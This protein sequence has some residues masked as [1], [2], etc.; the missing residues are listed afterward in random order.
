MAIMTRTDADKMMRGLDN[1]ADVAAMFDIPAALIP[2]WLDARQAL[3]TARALARA[4]IARLTVELDK[5]TGNGF[6]VSSQ[7]DGHESHYVMLSNGRWVCDC[8]AMYYGRV[9]TCVHAQTIRLR[10]HRSHGKRGYQRVAKRHNVG[11]VRLSR[12]VA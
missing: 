4:S 11:T 9:Y 3:D 6:Y 5:R 7:R 12:Y 1:A 10:A 8:E 2:A